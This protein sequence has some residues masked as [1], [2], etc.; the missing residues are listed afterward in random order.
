MI[1]RMQTV[2]GG[3]L[4][5]VCAAVPALAGGE[6]SVVSVDPAPHTMAPANTSITV[7]FDRVVD[8]ASVTCDGSFWA[9]AR[10]SGTVRGRI[11][12]EGGGT[13]AR[14]VPERSFSAG[15]LV[16]VYLSN[17]IRG[18]DGTS[19]RAAGY[20]FQF[21]VQSAPATRSFTHTQTRS[22]NAGAESSR[23]YGGIASDL[24]GDGFLD[25]TTVN[26]DTA[27]LRVLMNAGDCAGQ[28]D[29]FLQ[30]TFDVND[31]ASPSEPADFDRDGNVDIC[32]VNINTDT[33]SILLGNGDGTFAPQQEITVGDT[34]R[35]IATLDADGDGDIDVVNTNSASGNLCVLLNDGNGV[36]GAPT[37]FQGNISNEW[38]LAS[39]DMNR[40]GILDLVVGSQSADDVAVLNGNGDGTFT[41]SS[42]QA[43]GG[44]VWMIVVGDLNGDGWIDAT[45]ANSNENNGAVLLNDGAG[46]L[47]APTTYA[48]DAFPLATDLGDL[49]GDGDLDWI[50]AS[51]GGDWFVFR[52]DGLG[53]FTF[54]QEIVA[55]AAASCSLILDFDND[56]DCDLALIDEIADVVVFLRNDDHGSDCDA[57]G[58]R[59]A[60]EIASGAVEDCNGNGIPDSCDITSGTSDDTN[61]NGIPDECESPVA[62]CA[63]GAVDAG[64]GVAVEILAVNGQTGGET[65]VVRIATST[66]LAIT[67]D[68]APS[69]R[70]DGETSASCVYAWIGQPAA[71]DVVPLPKN[72]GSMCYGPFLTA[73]KSPRETWNSIG[74]PM[75]LGTDDAPGPAP[76]IPDGGSFELVSLPSG[77]GTSITA[78]FQGFVEDD[79]SQ[80][81]VPFSV[82]NGV[83]LV[84][85]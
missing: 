18:E 15:E 54:D 13:R 2:L 84:I 65:R 78:T 29:A 5:L 69:R 23:P 33:V 57:S 39:A 76:V 9:F 21:M 63:V 58:A 22:T 53:N 16:T 3:C 56:G 19:L 11:V 26:E 68:E 44:S 38:A 59:D 46:A 55:P 62:S 61:T 8:A 71:A 50:T 1:S 82:T 12:L 83:T 80:G 35:G 81:T 42:M 4:L 14:L 36:F 45:C 51:F 77:L 60:C 37:F 32:V 20:S 7:S 34:P 75:R 41:F 43:A 64:C 49:D 48:T 79:C 28:F 24:D 73:T 70:C 74:L 10:W 85:E 31:R 47:L 52:N 40:D 30:P 67:L 27:D 66:P 25:V 17:A 6:I 72:L